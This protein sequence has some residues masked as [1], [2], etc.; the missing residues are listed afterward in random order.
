MSDHWSWT[1]QD[2]VSLEDGTDLKHEF[3]DGDIRA[4]SGGTIEHARLIG[5]VGAQIAAQLGDRPCEYYSSVLRVRI[6]DLITY[7]DGSVACGEARM[8]AE[9]QLALIN[10]TLLVEVTSPSSE[11]YDRGGKFE[12]CKL[13]TSLREYVLVSHRTHA[14]DVFRRNDDG[15]W[16]DEPESYG[17]GERARLASIDCEIDVDKLYRRK[18]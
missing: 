11:R 14:I 5:A 15:T 10:P 18:I 12:R 1:V 3:F 17:P 7:P 9:D 4:M 16:N 2:Y 13:I 8:D 6:G